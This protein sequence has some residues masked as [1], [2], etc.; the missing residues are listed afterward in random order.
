MSFFNDR[1]VDNNANFQ[2]NGVTIPVPTEPPKFTYNNIS[3]GGRLA[4][5]IDYEGD[6]KG[7][8]RNIELKYNYMNKEHYD[9]MFNLTQ[10]QYNSG[11]SFFFTLKLPTYTSQGVETMTVYFMSSH[12]NNCKWSTE[13]YK[14]T[15]GS[16]YDYGG[17]KYD[18]LHEN[19]V[20]SFVEK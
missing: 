18:E 4:D 19:V 20:F 17:S 13:M 14:E 7:S 1:L 9:L 2:I 10:G 3:D 5:N 16:D 8:K 6:L 15:L 11:G 12:T